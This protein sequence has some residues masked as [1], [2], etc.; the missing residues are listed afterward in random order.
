MQG[1]MWRSY[2]ENNIYVYGAQIVEDATLLVIPTSI[3]KYQLANNSNLTMK[4]F[5]IMT[6]VCRQQNKELEHR[7]LQNASQRIGCFLL[8]LCKPSAK[9]KVRLHLPYDKMLI[10]A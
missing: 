1:L 6:S 5:K 7:D 4:M 9:K 2:F 10:A 8:R 3:L